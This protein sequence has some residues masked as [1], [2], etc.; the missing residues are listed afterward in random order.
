MTNKPKKNKCPYNK[1]QK[2]DLLYGHFLI[3]IPPREIITSHTNKTSNDAAN[4]STHLSA[5][6]K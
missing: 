2:N 5:V 6:T 1:P 3:I 4:L